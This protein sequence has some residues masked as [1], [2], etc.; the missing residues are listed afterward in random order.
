MRGHGEP[1][2]FQMIAIN[3]IKGKK[4]CKTCHVLQDE[5]AFRFDYRSKTLR[6][7]LLCKAC[8]RAY[9][10][11]NKTRIQSRKTENRRLN[12]EETN[13]INRAYYHANR[14][15]IRARYNIQYSESLYI[16]QKAADRSRQRHYNVTPEEYQR[17][18]ENQDY[19]CLICKRH[20]N[21][22]GKPL[23]VDH[24]HGCCPQS[25]RSCGKCVRGL[26][27]FNCNTGLGS[28]QDN[29][30]FLRIAANY[31]ESYKV[32]GIATQCL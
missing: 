24:D 17:K 8:Q 5:A 15:K 29:P 27:C 2:F 12:R 7:K 30:E 26:L 13:A 4:C 25:S 32:K 31:I 18:L 9:Y 22:L 21:E 11:K 6:L 14:N 20:A 1:D 16:Q 10:Q 3:L 23:G 19:R 28:L